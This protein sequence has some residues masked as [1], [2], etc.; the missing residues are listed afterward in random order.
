MAHREPRGTPRAA[1]L[2]SAEG[3]GACY[4]PA[5][6]E[7]LNPLKEGLM[8]LLN[9]RPAVLLLSCG[10]LLLGGAHAAPPSAVTKWANKAC[11]PASDTQAGDKAM[12]ARARC[13]HVAAP[14]P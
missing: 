7:E 5:P 2:A 4:C 11:P 8:N 13:L 6:L 1:R 9:A 3:R 10:L 14:T 12:A